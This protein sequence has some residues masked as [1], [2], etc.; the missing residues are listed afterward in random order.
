MKRVP[1]SYFHVRFGAV[2]LSLQILELCSEVIDPQVRHDIDL[3][4]DDIHRNGL[5]QIHNQVCSKM[6]MHPQTALW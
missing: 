1:Y 2:V 3:P 4:D 5:S 6:M